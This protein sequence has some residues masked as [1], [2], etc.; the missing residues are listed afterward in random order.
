MGVR[1]T[2]AKVAE[3]LLSH[4]DGARDIAGCAVAREN[5]RPG[6][7]RSAALR[8]EISDRHLD[9]RPGAIWPRPGPRGKAVSES[10][11]RGSGVPEVCPSAALP[12][13]PRVQA[14]S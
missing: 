14:L 1:G 11:F 7:A 9:A 2:D 3:G 8:A 12:R 10:L 13:G 4:R 5:L 6:N